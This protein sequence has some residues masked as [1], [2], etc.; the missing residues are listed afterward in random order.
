MRPA[1]GAPAASRADHYAQRR[2]VVR[3][4]ATEEDAYGSLT[5]AKAVRQ[6]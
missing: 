6:S 5:A 1:P 3:R 4:I 2:P